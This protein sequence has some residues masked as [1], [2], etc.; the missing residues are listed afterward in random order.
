MKVRINMI[1]EQ[2][3]TTNQSNQ[4]NQYHTMIAIRRQL[5]ET[6]ESAE[7]K[8]KY[9]KSA[10]KENIIISAVV[11]GVVLLLLFLFCYIR[12]RNGRDVIVMTRKQ[13]EKR[14]KEFKRVP[15]PEEIKERE[16][17]SARRREKNRRRG[18]GFKSRGGNNS[19]DTM[20]TIKASYDIEVG[21]V[22]IIEAE[23]EDGSCAI[24]ISTSHSKSDE[25]MKPPQTSIQQGN[26]QSKAHIQSP[27]EVATDD[28]YDMIDIERDSIE[29]EEAKKEDDGCGIEIHPSH[30]ES[31]ENINP[32]QTSI[33]QGND[34]SKAH[35]Q[36]PTEVTTDDNYGMIDIGRDSI[37]VEEAKKEDDGCGIEI[38]PV[39]SESGENINP[40]QSSIDQGNDQS[41]TLIQSPR[42]IATDDNYDM[43]DAERDSTEVEVSS[44]K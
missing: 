12:H 26:D 13:L 15:E 5:I 10:V 43:I 2:E 30:N 17:A 18:R 7:A 8:I 21:E 36:S 42:E 3:T 39:H 34:K 37:E 6:Q 4:S 32:P 16:A 22:N 20:E 28:N 35:I 24:E 29:V 19:L 14:K 9:Y 44:M 23:E 31:G 33:Q 25:N 41:K 11:G 38:S 40:P 1:H 27:T